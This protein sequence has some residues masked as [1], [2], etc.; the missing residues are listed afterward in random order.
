[1]D[2]AD[3]AGEEVDAQ[4]SNL[5]ALSGVSELAFLFNASLWSAFYSELC[6]V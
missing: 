1:M 6:V 3:T 4:V 2:V 5:L